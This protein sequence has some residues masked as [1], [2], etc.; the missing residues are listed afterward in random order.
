M[1]AELGLILMI[2][3]LNTQIL[4]AFP[5]DQGTQKVVIY[6]TS[7]NISIDGNLDEADWNRIPPIKQFLVYPT[8]Q[9]EKEEDTVAKM[10]WD[11]KNLYISFKAYDHYISATR[12]QRNTDV[13]NDDCVEVF[14]SPFASNPHIYISLEINALGTYLSRLN[15]TEKIEEALEAPGVKDFDRLNPKWHPPRLQIGRSYKGTMN[16]DSDKDSWWIIEVR[17]PFRLFRF[18]G[19]EKK[20]QEGEVW[21]FNLYRLGGEVNAFRRNL[22]YLPK[23]KSN[24]SPGYFGKL[25]FSKEKR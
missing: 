17:I 16:D 19:Y 10:L 21:R 8:Y 7:G 4:G 2:F 1:K 5:I 13:Y 18:V 24:H 23:G 15:L 20:P 3:I 6:R 25:V 12:T 14:V 11:N 22:F 9:S